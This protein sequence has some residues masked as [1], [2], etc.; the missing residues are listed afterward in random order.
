MLNPAQQ[1]ALADIDGLDLVRYDEQASS[2]PDAAE[3][4]AVLIPGFLATTDA[5]QLFLNE[6]GRH[7]LLTPDEEIELAFGA[8]RDGDTSGSE[9]P[10]RGSEQKAAAVAVAAVGVRGL[11]P[12]RGTGGAG[13]GSAG[14]A[15]Q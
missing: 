1:A 15:P 12:C 13:W 14:S 6:I 9:V 2:L 5:L 3:R 8:L 4:A 10:A 11:P 7:R